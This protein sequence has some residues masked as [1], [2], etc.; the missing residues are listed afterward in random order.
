MKFFD[1]R[2]NKTI[3]LIYKQTLIFYTSVNITIVI[4]ANKYEQK[5]FKRLSL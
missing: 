1:N 5:S 3:L 2:S 4:F